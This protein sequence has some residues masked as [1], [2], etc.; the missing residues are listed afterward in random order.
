M[1]MEMPA[2][3]I[4][5][6]NSASLEEM[7]EGKDGKNLDSRLDQSFIISIDTQEEEEKD[8]IIEQALSKLEKEDP[9]GKRLADII[10]RRYRSVERE[11]Q[12]QIADSYG[13]SRELV[14]KLERKAIKKLKAI[15][16]KME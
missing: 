1:N 11:T 15:I 8:A 6:K 5:E 4:P 7:L 13:R 3:R 9:V 2:K 14:G 12:E 10:R 16:K